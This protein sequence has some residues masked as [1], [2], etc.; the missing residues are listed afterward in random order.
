MRGCET[1]YCNLIEKHAIVAMIDLRTNASTASSGTASG[2]RARW[3][4]D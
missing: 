4:V 2:R 1:C 3:R